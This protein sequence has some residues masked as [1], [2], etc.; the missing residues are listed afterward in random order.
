MRTK[1]AGRRGNEGS[2]LG[3][4]RGRRIPIQAGRKTIEGARRSRAGGT[5]IGSLERRNDQF[6]SHGFLETTEK[7]AR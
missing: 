4:N 3:E 1:V 6:G 2:F 7:S 5:E